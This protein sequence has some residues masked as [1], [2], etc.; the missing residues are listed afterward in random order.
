[1]EPDLNYVKSYIFSSFPPGEPVL[2]PCDKCGRR[3]KYKESLSRHWHHECGVEPRFACTMC[4]YRTSRKAR[5]QLHIANKHL[6]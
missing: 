5:L 1:M 4:P 6:K 2:Y 3:Y